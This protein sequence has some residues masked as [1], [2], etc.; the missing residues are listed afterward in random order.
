MEPLTLTLFWQ[1]IGFAHMTWGK[2]AMIGGGIWVLYWSFTRAFEPAFWVPFG[3]AVALANLPVGG[4]GAPGGVLH[5]LYVLGVQSGILPLLIFLGLGTLMDLGPLLAMPSLLFVGAAAQ[6]GVFVTV[7]FVLTLNLVS[8]FQF[9]VADAASVAMVGGGNAP[10]VLFLTA[11]VAPDLLGAIV[12]ALYVGMATIHRLQP[13]IMRAL[14]TDTE[15]QTRMAPLRPVSRRARVLFPLAILLP[16]VLFLPVALP[17]LGLFAVG[18]VLRESG[19]LDR[20]SCL[21]GRRMIQADF[22]RVMMFLFA[23]AVGS[24][25]SAETF[26]SWRT[27]GIVLLGMVALGAGTAMGVLMGKLLYYK[28]DGGINPLIGAAGLPFVSLSARVVDK[29]GLEADPRGFLLVHAVGAHVAGVV[30]STVTL[31][32]FLAKLGVHL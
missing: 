13:P 17:V 8:G 2:A 6:L 14:T 24:Q 10:L 26:L 29:L 25:L 20:L 22:V 16:C 21:S 1:T 11:R 3:C 19:L 28:S 9:D 12:L 4:V 27:V 7:F 32:V 31:A 5:D 15:R 23:L 30:G 18:N